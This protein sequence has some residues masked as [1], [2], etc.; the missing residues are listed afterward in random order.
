M[1]ISTLLA[2]PY[3]IPVVAALCVAFLIAWI[4]RLEL[5]IGGLLGK[6]A[7]SIEEAVEETRSTIKKV[8]RVQKETLA[9]LESVEK[10]LQKS[11][12]GVGTVRFNP[13][14]GQGEG[15]NQSFSTALLNEEGNGVVISSLYSRDRVS[16][17]SKPLQ[18]FSSEYELSDEEK[19]A[20]EKA[21]KNAGNDK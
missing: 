19:E 11:I 21:K 7:H 4:V 15:G 18:K 17:F 8:E 16:V 3:T 5:R 9:Y 14:K 10:R 1:D 2:H 13:F 20:V 6:N 12:Q